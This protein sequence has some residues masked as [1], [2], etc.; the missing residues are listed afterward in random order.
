MA[1]PRA[2]ATKIFRGDDVFG[3]ALRVRLSNL[4]NPAYVTWDAVM[5]SAILSVSYVFPKG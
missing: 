1:F 5:A 4:G 2:E 3:G